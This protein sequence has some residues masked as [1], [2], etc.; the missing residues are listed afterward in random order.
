MNYFYE[1]HVTPSYWVTF[2]GYRLPSI[3]GFLVPI[4]MHQTNDFISNEWI[5]NT[6]D[7]LLAILFLLGLF[8]MT[9]Y[10]L[11]LMASFFS[12]ISNIFN[13]NLALVIFSMFLG[14]LAYDVSLVM[15]EAENN[16]AIVFDSFQNYYNEFLIQFTDYCFGLNLANYTE[17]E[18]TT[19]G[20]LLFIMVTCVAFYYCSYIYKNHRMFALFLVFVTIYIYFQTFH[21]TPE[22][23]KFFSNN[24]SFVIDK[25]RT[26]ASI[27]PNAIPKIIV[28]LVVLFQLINNLLHFFRFFLRISVRLIILILLLF[29]FIN[30]FYSLGFVRNNML[31]FS[32][33]SLGKVIESSQHATDNFE[34]K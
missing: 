8:R 34:L 21:I 23:I 17:T 24:K 13:K 32:E 12:L 25:D 1:E 7:V 28:I 16:L 26:V 15:F 2:K 19:W 9:I 14:Y 20:S 29:L 3:R 10:G 5:F 22:T 31:H 6:I 27:A 18:I 11:D 30:S 33:E 4:N